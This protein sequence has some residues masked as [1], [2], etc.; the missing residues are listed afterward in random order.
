[1]VEVYPPLVRASKPSQPASWTTEHGRAL[2]RSTTNRKLRQR[3]AWRFR[4][5]MPD[6]AALRTRVGEGLRKAAPML[7]VVGVF[8]LA[9]LGAW[10][11]WV[12]LTHSSRFAVSQIVVTGNTRVTHDDVVARAGLAPGTNLFEV[13]LDQIAHALESD[14]WISDAAVSR[15]MPDALRI[16]VHERQPAGLLVVEDATYLVDETGK[17]FKRA[18]LAHGEGE[19][20]V[21]VTGMERATFTR[22]AEQAAAAVRE[23]LTAARRWHEN[24]ERPRVG[25]V[26]LARAGLTLYTLEGAVAVRLGR[27]RGEDL[28]ARLRRFDA[29]WASLS[30]EERAVCKTIFLD[31]ATRADRVTVQLA[32]AR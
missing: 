8:G 32:D 20:L 5:R 2:R 29:I 27:A 30:E 7:A 21:V 9:G 24:A 19:G 18:E 25:E 15:Q 23:A 26:H 17:P 12:W 28:A 11:G 4:L 31:S 16:A 1:M 10:R 14:P 13:S 22:D 3:R 6:W